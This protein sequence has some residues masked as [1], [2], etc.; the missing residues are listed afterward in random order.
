MIKHVKFN[1][2]IGIS[3]NVINLNSP[4]VFIGRNNVGKNRFIEEMY[5]FP[6]LKLLK[7]YDIVPNLNIEIVFEVQDYVPGYK[8]FKYNIVTD[9]KNKDAPILSESLMINADGK[10]EECFNRK[11]PNNETILFDSETDDV[12]ICIAAGY[13]GNMIFI[14]PENLKDKLNIEEV[15]D[16]SMLLKLMKHG[17]PEINEFLFNEPELKTERKECYGFIDKNGM[18]RVFSDGGMWLLT[19]LTELNKEN[20]SVIFIKDIEHSLDIMSLN[21]IVSQIRSK[22]KWD[23]TQIIC[24]THSP[25]FLD[26]M[27]MSHIISTRQ[28]EANIEYYYPN[29]DDTLDE[30]RKHFSPGQLMSK[31]M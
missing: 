25:Y 11:V 16:V 23:E 31:I 13:L 18:S 21:L 5:K 3:P 24:S 29:K 14:T 22:L 19:I 8:E 20:T 7:H 10:Y 15:Y 12:D 27:D 2:T 9:R 1:D 26:L 28:N 30:W 4:S 6:A 17:I